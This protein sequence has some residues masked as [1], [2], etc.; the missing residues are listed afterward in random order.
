MGGVYAMLHATHVVADYWFQT[1]WQAQNKTKRWDALLCHIAV[2]S[3][4]FAWTGE[5]LWQMAAIPH[6]K[7]FALPLV[8]GIPHGWMDRRKFLTW[9]CAVTKG[10]KPEDIPTLPP[11]QTAVRVHVSTRMDQKFH[12]FCLMLTAAWLA[13]APT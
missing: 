3:L 4:S 5:L 10:W 9:F 12:Y 13:W 1:D 7:V 8:V 6:W 2:Y 11:I